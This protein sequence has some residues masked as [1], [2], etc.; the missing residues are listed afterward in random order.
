MDYQID[1]NGQTQGSQPGIEEEMNPAPI[2][3]RENYRG[4]GKLQGKSALITGGDSGIGRAVAVHFAREGADVAIVYLEEDQDAQETKSLVEAEGK[5]C[6][7]IPGDVRNE[8]FCKD[9]VNQVVSEFGKLNILV[10][11]AAEQHPKED[12]REIS[13][14]QLQDTFATN[15]FA[16]FYFTQAALEHLQEHDTIINTTSVTAYHG[17]PAC[18]ITHRPKVQLWLTR[19]HSR[20]HLQ[21]RK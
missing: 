3:I 13:A 9:A 14:D 17:S 6:L 5:R 8:S 10:N 1:T 19:A 20:A 7:L 16:F 11:N 12:V 2:F 18:S 15:I 21:I 4:S